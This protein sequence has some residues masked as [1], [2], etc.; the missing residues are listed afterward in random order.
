MKGTRRGA[1]PTVQQTTLDD[2]EALL[3]RVRRRWLT[4]RSLLAAGRVGGAATGLL[5]L[6]L[7]TDRVLQPADAVMVWLFAAALGL[8]AGLAG[9]ALWR[10]RRG[11]GNRQVARYI[12]ERCPGL[13]ERLVSA[14]DVA[15]AARPSVFRDLL[16]RDAAR[17]ARAVDLDRVLPRRDVLLAVAAA[18]LAVA[19]LLL[20]VVFGGGP[21]GRIARTTWL[22]AFPHAALLQVEPGDARVVAGRP[23]RLR[24][25]LRSGVGGATRSLP[26]VTVTA[27][28]G[29]VRALEMAAARDAYQL[30]VPAVDASF[31]YRVQ[32]ASLTSDEY[33]ITAVFPPRVSRI[34][35]A[36]QYPAHTGL[37]PR[38][39]ADGGDIHAP[40]G[41]RVTVSVRTSKAVDH[42]WLELGA[43]A[44]LPLETVD[45]VLAASFDVL[46][47]DTYRVRLRDADGL[48]NARGSDYFIRTLQDRAPAVELLRPAGDREITPLEEVTVEARA[49]DDFGLAR[50]ELVYGVMGRPER[51]V[52]LGAAAGAAR[53]SG[54]YTIFGED[55]QLQPGDFL[56]Y[57]VRARDTA[58][59]RRAAVR[60]D[61]YF[62]Q[63]RPFDREFEEAPSQGDAGPETEDLRRL[64]EVQKEIIVATW[65]LDG[66]PAAARSG[67]DVETVADAQG[68][69]KLAAQ[70]LA[71]RLR[72]PVPQ[73][74]PGDAPGGDALDLA[75][76]AMA[77][78]ETELRGLRTAAAIPPEMTA[79]NQL[80]RAQ[81]S[82]GPTQVTQ[83]G[84]RR[85]PGGGMG[86][87]EDLSALFDRDLRRDQQTNYEHRSPSEAP[88]EAREEDEVRRRLRALAE[89]QAALNRQQ[90]ELARERALEAGERRRRLERLAR[91]QEEIRRRTE[92]LRRALAQSGEAG[93]PRPQEGQSAARAMRDA[94]ERMQRAARELGQGDVS[95]AAQAGR[96][97]LDG[98]RRLG[99][100]LGGER[101]AGRGRQVDLQLEAQ[102][103]ADAQREVA[104]AAGGG[105]GRRA[106][107]ATRRQ[108][109]EREDHLAGRV[110]SLAERI[111]QSRPAAA[112]A[113]QAALDAAA[114]ELRQ[115]EVARRMRAFAAALREEDGAGAA[116]PDAIEPEL[117]AQLAAA[118]QRVAEE[119]SGAGEPGEDTRRLAEELAESQRLRDRLTRIEEQLAEGSP[120]ARSGAQPEGQE[121]GAGGGLG[122]LA[123]LLAQL[124]EG[125]PDLARDL[126]RWARDWRSG[127][128]PGTEAYKQDLSAWPALYGELR[129]VLEEL[130]ASRSRALAADEAADR[131]LA[132]AGAA[133]PESY[134]RLVD[135][136][137][138]SLAAR[139]VPR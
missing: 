67:D 45:G 4:R 12:E 55:L 125:R 19:A 7:V 130:E 17:T 73:V 88:D 139:P 115:A 42:G 86:A 129:Y 101:T 15:A 36:Y 39:E 92:D 27:G 44:R 22:H 116:E 37:A 93:D 8:A 128:A 76:D 21:L 118:L 102:Q 2:L 31:T 119:L 121:A 65:K 103:L 5:L 6:V 99:Q 81:A 46:A 51:V 84:S 105:R 24:A 38:V 137:Y 131:L 66:E 111:E 28:D 134:R 20:V 68:D 104:A 108:L 138:R 29:T 120:G 100:R 63:V 62:L 61:I 77:A 43:G 60:S 64:A 95:Q 35:V 16:L 79:F 106:D 94:V 54:T 72:G 48:A 11:P 32:A 123:D 136:Y 82:M 3:A 9:R 70:Q 126:E 40:A 114:R 133:T 109:A 122:E 117:P 132:G 91:E 59:S 71:A 85:G 113:E 74:V 53:A 57:H 41:T 18:G 96:Q 135:R 30:D 87:R 83:R 49:V 69:L 78:A 56:T 97:A 1:G 58:P 10:L 34:D 89:R 124:G 50:F 90:E 52:S 107:R 47:D 25:V 13:E 14:A 112:P 75:I 33:A 127:A 110:E 23:L 98:L 80:L 26:V